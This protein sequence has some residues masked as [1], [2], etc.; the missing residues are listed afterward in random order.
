VQRFVCFFQ[1]ERLCLRAHR[2]VSGKREEVFA[3]ATGEIRDRTDDALEPKVRVG[4][5]GDVAHVNPAAN[6]DAA[7]IERAQSRRNKV[8]DWREDDRGVEFLGWHFIRTA[9]PHRAEPAR[10]FLPGSVVRP[11]EC[12]DVAALMPRYLRDDVCRCT[13]AINPQ[14]FCV[15]RLA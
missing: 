8:A 11:G 4:K 10:E 6:N 7:A 1:A 2:N 12:V 3:I 13:E 15:A 9:G 5:G 14:P